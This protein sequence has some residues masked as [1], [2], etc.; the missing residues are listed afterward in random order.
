MFEL[1][2]GVKTDILL[3][4]WHHSDHDG[5]WNQDIVILSENSNRKVGGDLLRCREQS[6]KTDN[7]DFYCLKLLGGL[8]MLLKPG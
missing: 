5:V 8:R 2:M 1:L 7:T 4:A 6:S 3:L